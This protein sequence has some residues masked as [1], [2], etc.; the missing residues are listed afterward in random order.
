MLNRLCLGTV[1]LG[2]KYGVNNIIKR[3]PSRDESNELLKKSLEVGISTF[4]TASVYGNAEEILGDFG[5]GNYN[6]N[7]IS[8]LKP[9][10]K[11]C[12]IENT[13]NEIMASLKR[14]RLS[15]L[16]GYLIHDV[17]D[18]YNK[19]IVKGLQI[20]KE[21]RFVKNIGVSIYEP[22]DALNAVK[23]SFVDYIQI[24]YNVFDQ[25]LNQT[26][27]FELAE[28]NKI[29]IFARSSFLQGLLLMDVN[30]MPP[31][32]IDAKPYLIEFEKIIKEYGFSKAEA[33]FLFSYCNND[34]HKI[35]FGVETKT[36]L[37]TNVE[38]IT[39]A[40]EFSDCYNNLYLNLNFKKIDRKILT[41]SLWR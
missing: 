21:E 14:L 22:E 23:S 16:D 29:K 20:C 28:K 39:R 17:E 8:K 38:I 4:D 13:K 7:V 26:D 32:L 2:L 37:L 10:I 12:I 35:V 27:F 19:D 34:L 11:E 15:S 25:R 41:P 5:I 3:K 36:Q 31:Y 40:T 18:F 9:G 24:P 30:K 6:V 1:Q 33:S